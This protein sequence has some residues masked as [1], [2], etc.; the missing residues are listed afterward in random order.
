M[1]TNNE[2]ATAAFFFN[3]GLRISKGVKQTDTGI[4]ANENQVHLLDEDP[5]NLSTNS[6]DPEQVK[7]NVDTIMSRLRAEIQPTVSSF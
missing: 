7:Q 4:A 2:Q 6:D 3:E 1:V 5:D